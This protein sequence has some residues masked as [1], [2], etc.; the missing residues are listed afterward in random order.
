MT[1]TLK[2]LIRSL[3]PAQWLKNGFVLAPIVFSGRAGDGDAWLRSLLAVA[4]FCAASSATYLLND[5]L[6]READR[7]HPSKRTRPIAS[8]ELSVAAALAAAALAAV[9]AVAAAFV[10]GG[11][12]PHVLGGYLVLTVLY[13]ALL[14]ELVF[15]DVLVVAA[16][17]VLRVVGGA[18]AIPVP[19]SRW[20]LLC[21]YLLALYLALG[22]RRAELALLGEGAGNHRV[23]LGHYT[24]PLVD[25]AI[26]VV[27]GATV[28]AY[29]LY[30]VAPETVAKVGSEGLMVTVPVVLYGLL[31]YLYLLHRQELGGSP[32][33][34]L[35][36]DRPLLACVVVWLA[37]A[38][39]VVGAG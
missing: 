22:K 16:G 12:F 24:L 31:R 34:V 26:S 21:A 39:I 7:Q 32:T 37:V 28:L 18:A 29:T 30:T 20:L 17:F 19:V 9:L 27:L 15:I 6:D 4:A 11:W 2:A 1:R 23:V 8:G 33:R 5:V 36:L 13:S 14:K 35:M 25:Q 10:L 38:A 3:R